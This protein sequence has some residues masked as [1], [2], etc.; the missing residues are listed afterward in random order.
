MKLAKDCIDIDVRTNQVEPMLDFRTKEIGL[1]HELLKTG[2]DARQHRLVLNGSSIFKLNCH[3]EEISDTPT[4]G[5]KE[6]Y[7]AG[8]ADQPLSR[9]DPV[10]NLVTLLPYGLQDITRTDMR[11]TVR[12]LRDSAK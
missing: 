8:D 7:I 10:R 3:R 2:S 11:M 1:T 4:S 12:S 5:Y 6:L 9:N